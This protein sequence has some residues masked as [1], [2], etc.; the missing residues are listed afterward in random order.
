MPFRSEE[1]AYCGGAACTVARFRR[2]YGP[3]L[4]AGTVILLEVSVAARSRIREDP[5][6]V[7]RPLRCPATQGRLE[8]VT[9]REILCGRGERAASNGYR[10][11]D[12]VDG[13]QVV[14]GGDQEP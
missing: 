2:A 6:R 5:W 14:D 8:G 7:G 4:L 13:R 11:P 1:V 12:R 9:V 10:A 3:Q